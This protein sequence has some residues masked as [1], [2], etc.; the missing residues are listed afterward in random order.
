M[1]SSM[2]GPGWGILSMIFWILIVGVIIYGILTLILKPFEKHNRGTGSPSSKTEDSALLILRER[3]A[4]GEINEEEY[5]RKR[6]LL[7]KQNGPNVL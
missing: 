4:R 6:D 3:Y 1:M 2:M 7:N 5:E